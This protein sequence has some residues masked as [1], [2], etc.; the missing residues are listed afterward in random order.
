MIVISR[1]E[2]AEHL[3]FP[4]CIALMRDAMAALSAGRTRQLLRQIIDLDGKG[5]AFGVMPGAMD[6]LTFGAKLIS[7]Y[8][9][10]FLAGK[11]SHQGLITLFD[12]ESGAPVCLIHAGEVTAIRTAAASAAATDALARADATRLAILGY[13][14]QAWQHVAA[15]RHVRPL[16]H[17]A[18]WGR[19]SEQAQAFADRVHAEFGLPATAAPNVGSAVGDADIICTTTAASE[20]ILFSAQ[21]PDGAHL[22]IVGSSRP[23]PVEIDTDLVVRCRVFADHRASVLAQGAEILKA[24][25]SGLISEDHVLG[26]IGQVYTKGGIPGR[27]SSLN[28]TLYK[29]LGSIVQDL[30]VGWHLYRL[31]REKSFGSD[32]PF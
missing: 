6:D 25:E 3:D 14:E 13:G 20:P 22:N 5:N 30:A 19:S 10:N 1:E 24:L 16:S 8:P 17:V 21:V 29:S 12:P 28:L 27:L 11:Q 9:G 7:V 18:V 2:V 4:T 15:I 32:V 31:A 23:G 26:E